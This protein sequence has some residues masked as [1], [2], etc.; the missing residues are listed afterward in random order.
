[1]L[2]GYSEPMG[3]G[4]PAVCGE[5]FYR[6]IFECRECAV[7]RADKMQAKVAELQSLVAALTY[8]PIRRVE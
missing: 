5:D 2:C 1:M 7:K 6:K 3:Q 8:N 4:A